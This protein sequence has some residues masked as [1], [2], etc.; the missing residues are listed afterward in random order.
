MIRDRAHL[1]KLLAEMAKAGVDDV[2]LI[3]G[4]ATPPQGPY[5]SAVEL[6]PLISEHPRRPGQIGIAG[7]PEGHP[8]I[9]TSKLAEA[10]EQK[11]SLAD[12][13]TTQL[14]FDTDALLAWVAETRKRGVTLPLLAG[15]PGAV[16][17]A[18]L[19]RVSMRI[20]VGASLSFLRRQHG[21]R[22][23]LAHPTATADRV[24]DALVP[25]LDDPELNIIGF[26]YYTFNQLVDTWMWERQKDDRR[27]MVAIS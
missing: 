26:H 11:S 14:C 19:L 17:R 27:A 10:L 21:L 8:R 18:R 1:D 15:V 13:I 12:Y 3:G 6:L 7:Y 25:S 22:H 16:D 20:G 24:H 9:D 2:F 23:L 4:D 5:S